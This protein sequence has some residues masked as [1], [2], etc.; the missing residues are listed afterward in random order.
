[1]EALRCSCT[2]QFHGNM[3]SQ[4]AGAANFFPVSDVD[5]VVYLLLCVTAS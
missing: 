5:N 1:M 2:V 4:E 3:K